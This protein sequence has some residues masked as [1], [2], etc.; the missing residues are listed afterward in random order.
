MIPLKSIQTLDTW[1]KQEETFKK[2]S[3]VASQGVSQGSLCPG[4]AF[5]VLTM[6]MEK[7]HTLRAIWQSQN[8]CA[9]A[10]GISMLHMRDLSSTS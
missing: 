3:H 6:L 9:I 5:M 10:S 2:K 1:L 4:L 7:S 8:L